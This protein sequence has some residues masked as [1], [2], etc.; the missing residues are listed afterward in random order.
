MKIDV[1]EKELQRIHPDL[2]VL[3]NPK[4][5]TL[6]GVYFQGTFLFGVPN[7]NIYDTE[8]KQYGADLPN[9]MFVR[10]RTRP[11]ALAMAKDQVAQLKSANQDDADAILGRGNYSPDA[12]AA[13][14]EEM[15]LIET[16]ASP[17]SYKLNE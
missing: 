2:T 6:A 14:K 1:F 9:G 15:N 11:E 17:E 4:I 8:N 5:D 13:T 10:H 16:S 3:A 7:H 12:L